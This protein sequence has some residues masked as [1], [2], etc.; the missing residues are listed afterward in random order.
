M[1]HRLRL[2]KMF[3][4]I[5]GYGIACLS[6][7]QNA[8]QN[9]SAI[10]RVLIIRPGGIGD[11]VLSI[12]GIQALARTYHEATIEVVAEQRNCSVFLLCSGNIR[13]L[14]YDNP[15]QFFTIFKQ[16][17]DIV[18]DTEQYHRLSA[19]VSKLTN[20]PVT[21]GYATNERKKLFNHQIPY[22]HDEY[23]VES[24]IKLLA[25]LGIFEEFQ[26]HLPFLSIPQS[27]QYKAVQLLGHNS[28]KAFVVIFPGASIPERRWGVAQFRAVAE[29]LWTKGFPV[30]VVGG[31]EDVADGDRII[32][33][34]FG[35]NLAG[36]TSHA[37]TA[38]IIEKA[39]LLVS[40]DSGILHIA[41]GLGKPT[42]SLF[43]PGIAKKWAPRGDQ[44]IVINKNLPCSPCTKFGYTPKCPIKAKC[45]ADITVDEV[46]AAVEKLL[47]NQGKPGE[48]QHI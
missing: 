28:E 25:P 12:P 41:V 22:S 38:A 4:R 11:A 43:G 14:R 24:F 34:E 18:I 32:N 29:Q 45:M 33:R 40:G 9:I 27:A 26:H 15:C 48:A 37:E 20:A 7:R 39:A 1:K 21:I 13:V 42:V 6:F 8:V 17:Y 44:H 31:K 30:V 47:Q 5:I 10:N 36:N 35:L 19:V 23:E 2:I 46:V 16:R 3:D